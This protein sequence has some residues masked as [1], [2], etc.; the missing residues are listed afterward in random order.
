MKVIKVNAKDVF[1]DDNNGL[2]FGLQDLDDFP[3]YIEWF[4]TEEERQ[5]AIEEN[6][7]EVI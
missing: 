6:N 1:E 7:F 4:K 3:N 2:I 5:K